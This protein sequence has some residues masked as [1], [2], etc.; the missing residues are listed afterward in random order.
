MSDF[1]LKNG[2]I[3]QYR[4]LQQGDE[5][6]LSTFNAALSEKSRTLF[7]PHGYNIET[8]AKVINRAESGEDAAY[9]ALDKERIAAYWFLWWFNTPFP[10]LG[11][12]ILDE[13]HGLGLGKQLIQHLINLAETGGCE[14]IELTTALDNEAGQALYEKTGFKRIGTVENISGD[15]KITEEIHMVYSIKPGIIPP[16]RKHDSPV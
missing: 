1:T 8:L 4:K 2:K 9:I 16:P 11:I 14:A 6:L 10:V 13:F 5:K 7:M 12:G 3:L 15:G